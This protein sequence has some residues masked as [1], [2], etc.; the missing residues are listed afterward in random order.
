MSRNEISET[1]LLAFLVYFEQASKAGH[2]LQC[3]KRSMAYPEQRIVL[4]MKNLFHKF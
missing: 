2:F 4:F 3:V 1:D